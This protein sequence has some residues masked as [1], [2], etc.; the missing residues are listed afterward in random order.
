[1]NNHWGIPIVHHGG[2]LFGYKSDWMIMPDAGMGALLLTNS[3]RGGS[4]LGLLMRR[5]VEVVYDG[6]L[7]TV[8]SVDASASNYRTAA[9]D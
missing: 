3:D 9:G 6:R 7:E 2:S 4:L 5:L 1:M 8:A